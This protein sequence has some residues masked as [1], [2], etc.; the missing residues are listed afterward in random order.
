MNITMP[1]AQ[2]CWLLIVTSGPESDALI[3]CC[4]GAGLAVE[5]IAPAHGRYRLQ[6]PALT[7]QALAEEVAHVAG[8]SLAV[9]QAPADSIQL[10]GALAPAAPHRR[11]TM[12]HGIGDAFRMVRAAVDR[13]LSV[14]PVGL[15]RWAVSG[16]TASQI[17]W[18][19]EAQRLSV[20][21]VLSAWNL[22][23]ESAA[24]E[25]AGLQVS[26]PI[27]VNIAMPARR[28]ETTAIER[29]AAGNIARV[30]Q[31]ESDA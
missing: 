30:E 13:R 16:S 31:V 4:V 23:P 3:A 21:D 15:N 7:L 27:T 5:P 1:A 19:T 10:T 12:V 8:W 29:D 22:T 25:D 14:V 2:V 18:L 24:A 20:A 28:T 26:V 9:E 6:G 17:A 11:T